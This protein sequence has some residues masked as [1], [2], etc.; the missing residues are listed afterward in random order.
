[1]GDFSLN[2]KVAL[3]TG[4]SS[5]IG[6]VTAEKLALQGYQVFLACRSEEKTQPVLRAISDQSQGQARAEFIALDLGDLDSVRRCAE[7]FLAR[8]LPLHLLI[9]NAGLAGHKGL[10]RSGFELTFGTCH[11]GHFLL[12]QLLLERL[13]ASQPARVVVVASMAH[14]HARSIDF[15]ALRQPTQSAAGLKEYSVAKLANILFAAELSR[16]LQGSGV[17]TYSLHPGVVATD[18]WRAIPA[19][20]AGLIKRFMLSEEQGAA[21]TLHCATAAAL[22]QQSGLYYS[23]CKEAEPSPLARDPALA[24]EL[25]AQTERWLAVS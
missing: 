9:A 11:V 13:K 12:T 8:N 10:T 7:T 6:R 23:S 5:G 2:D 21:T 20:F 1:M 4:A 22:S 16:R 18:V 14:R 24:R 19:P 3:I 17:T 15:A 25:W